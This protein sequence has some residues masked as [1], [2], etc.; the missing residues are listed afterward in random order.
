MA[1]QAKHA[2]FV[3]LNLRLPPDLHKRLREAA[4]T[5]RSL[6]AEILDRLQKSFEPATQNEGWRERFVAYLDLDRRAEEHFKSL[7]ARLDRLE[8]WLGDGSRKSRRKTVARV[9]KGPKQD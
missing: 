4:G 9:P 6:N 1:K 3:A 8:G 2:A 5:T 7:A